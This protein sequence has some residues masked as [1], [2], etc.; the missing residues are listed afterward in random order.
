MPDRTYPQKP[1]PLRRLPILTAAAWMLLA[2]A[3]PFA[4]AQD[5]DNE[6]YRI[7][8]MV[9]TANKAAKDK[10][11]ISANITAVDGLTALAL[12]IDALDELTALAP[13]VHFNKIDAHTTQLNF[14][15]IG[16]MANM[17]KVWNVNVDGVTVPYVGVDTLLDVERVELLRGSQGSLY[18]RNTHAGVVNVITRNPGAEFSAETAASVEAFNTQKFTAA[19]GGPAGQKVGY[20]LAVGYNRGDGFMENGYLGTDDGARH[21]QFSGRGKIRIDASPGNVFTLS[22]TADSYDGDFDVF[23]P[24][25]MGVSTETFNNEPGMNEGDLLSPTLTWEKDLGGTKA[26][27]HHQ[28]Q[29]FPLRHPL[30]PGLQPTG[31]D[32]LR[33]R[34]GLPHPDPGDPSG[35]RSRPGKP[36]VA[37]R[38]VFHVREDRHG[39]RFRLRQRRGPLRD[40][41]RN[42]HAIRI[43]D[44]QPRGGLV[45]KG[46]LYGSRKTG[47]E[48]RSSI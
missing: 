20:R 22:M 35:E 47:D 7:E 1:R 8:P 12:G 48:C 18:G 14:R 26:H 2:T 31:P 10:Q 28:L 34:R 5:A 30:R 17:N 11:E 23:R 37:G 46:H 43:T 39:L 33:L 13:N 41:V 32:G 42:V 38:R 24:L 9:V 27:R 45:R 36:I 44:R 15:G 4:G 40:G 29:Q 16:G 21:E 19:L 3:G 25:S 6:A